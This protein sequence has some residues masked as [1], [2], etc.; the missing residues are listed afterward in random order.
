MG[1]IRIGL[2]CAAAATASH[3]KQRGGKTPGFSLK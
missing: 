3:R 2:H 1:L